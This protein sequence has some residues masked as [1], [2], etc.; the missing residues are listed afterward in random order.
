VHRRIELP[1]GSTITRAPTD[2]DVRGPNLTA[3]RKT[4]SSGLVLEDSFTLSLP[5][6]TVAA[7]S[8][9]L[10]VSKV[11]AVDNGFMAG[12]RVQVKP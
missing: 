5:T 7:D 6:G 4:T 12:T 8:Y 2:L 11:Q 1:A 10:F 9:P 3:N